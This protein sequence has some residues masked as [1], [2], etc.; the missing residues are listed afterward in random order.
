MSCLIGNGRLEA[1]KDSIS[2]IYNIFFINFG[3]IDTVTYSGT[4][5]DLGRR[6][7]RNNRRNQALQI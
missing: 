1:C 2:G 4:A 6:Y 7:T 3:E 5:P